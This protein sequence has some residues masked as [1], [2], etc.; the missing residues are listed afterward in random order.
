MMRCVVLETELIITLD[1][2][3][4]AE[5]KCQT[6]ECSGSITGGLQSKP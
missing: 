4:R 5:V 6:D 2:L 3:T 1:E